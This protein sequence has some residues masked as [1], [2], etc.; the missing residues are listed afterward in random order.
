MN[1]DWLQQLRQL[2]EDD[3]ARHPARLEAEEQAPSPQRQASDLLRQAR[4]HE[5]LRQVQKTLLDGQGLLDIFERKGQYDRV[6]TLVWQGPISA[7]RKPD[8]DD[9]AGYSYILVG[10]R[11]GRLWVNGKALPEASPAALKAALVLAARNPGRER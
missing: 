2:R 9:P 5:L 6:L 10:V 4:A 3:L 8:P 7:A 11:N 1:D